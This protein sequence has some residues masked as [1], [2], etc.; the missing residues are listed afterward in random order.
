MSPSDPNIVIN[1]IGL[2][3]PRRSNKSQREVDINGCFGND[4]STGLKF[5][6][7]STRVGSVGRKVDIDRERS[8]SGF[9]SRERRNPKGDQISDPS[10][11]QIN[12]LTASDIGQFFVNF[13]NA[14]SFQLILDR[15]R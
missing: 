12:G 8:S 15:S 2:Q 14:H 4:H 1:V 3:P 6:I 11:L 9:S 10:F 7:D 13:D 5:D